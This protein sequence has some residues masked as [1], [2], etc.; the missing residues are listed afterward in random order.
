VFS[1][2]PERRVETPHD[3]RHLLVAGISDVAV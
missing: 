2:Q 1:A 3:R